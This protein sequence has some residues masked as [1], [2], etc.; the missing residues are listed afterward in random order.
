M[1]TKTAE[2][3][4]ISCKL[5]HEIFDYGS[6]DSEKPLSQHCIQR[7]VTSLVFVL[8]LTPPIP[9]APKHMHG[10]LSTMLIA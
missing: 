2:F 5:H 10:M 7:E 3:Y 9:S 4:F 1:K 8:A 6:P